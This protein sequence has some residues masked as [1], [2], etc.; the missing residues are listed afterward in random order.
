MHYLAICILQACRGSQIDPGFDVTDSKDSVD[1]KKARIPVEP[2]FLIAYSGVDGIIFQS[3]WCR[4]DFFWGN[5]A[6][7]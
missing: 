4:Q 6:A 5:A 1:A 7:T 2:D 3:Q